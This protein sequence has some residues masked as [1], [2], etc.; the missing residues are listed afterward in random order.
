MKRSS[1]LLIKFAVFAGL[2]LVLWLASD[3]LIKHFANRQLADMNASIDY[4][5][6]RIS[7]FDLSLTVEELQLDYKNQIMLSV[8]QLSVDL[9]SHALTDKELHFDHL[10]IGSFYFDNPKFLELLEQR[11]NDQDSG[12]N[13]EQSSLPLLVIDDVSASGKL[14]FS[15]DKKPV[16]INDFGANDVSYGEQGYKAKLSAVLNYMQN[17]L[18]VAGALN[19]D[20]DQIKINLKKL[21]GQLNVAD[22]NEFSEINLPLIQGHIDF[23]ATA[24]VSYSQQ[25]LSI[26]SG[27]SDLRISDGLLKAATGADSSELEISFEQFQLDLSNSQFEMK[28]DALSATKIDIEQTDVVIKNGLVSG[29]LRSDNADSQIK[30]SKIQLTATESQVSLD[31]QNQPLQLDTTVNIDSERLDWHQLALNN[32]P[33]ALVLHLD[34]ATLLGID[35]SQTENSQSPT[36]AMDKMT[37]QTGIFSQVFAMPLIELNKDKTIEPLLEFNQLSLDKF[38]LA[39]DELVIGGIDIDAKH[40]I[41]YK[42]KDNA[43]ANFVD[44]F[45]SDEE[46]AAAGDV[47]DEDG[48]QANN[49]AKQK[50]TANAAQEHDVSIHVDRFNLTGEPVITLYDHSLSETFEQHVTIEQLSLS[51]V[52]RA[53]DESDSE[54][55][56]FSLKGRIGKRAR[57]DIDGALYPFADE[58]DLEAKG[59]LKAIDLKRYTPYVVDATGYAIK[60][61]LL[62]ADFQFAINNDVIKGDVDTRING[63]EISEL[64]NNKQ[65]GS[66]STMPI[67]V[68]ISQLSDEHGNVNVD[69]PLAGRIDD[70]NFGLSGFISLVTTKAIKEGAKTYLLQ[71]LVPY[72]SVVNVAMLASGSLFKVSVND[73][74]YETGQTEL[75][76]TQNEFIQ[77]LAELMQSKEEL[78]LTICPVVIGNS[79]DKAQARELRKVGQLRG[80]LFIDAMI[81]QYQIS[82]ERLI[83][84]RTKIVEKGVVGLTFKFN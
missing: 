76:P 36:V 69:V 29:V 7:P 26:A 43:I 31:Q 13:S 28:S 9:N 21:K 60:Q 12:D 66:V 34:A 83:P 11:T 35:I 44:L 72:A 51:N 14:L 64:Q 2:W 80:E 71:A 63:I 3:P 5:S 39:N 54:K 17:S 59:Q 32:E 78:H 33:K 6:A 16:T 50:P 84:C 56:K 79:E 4:K 48:Q 42:N 62:Y 55:A 10:H 47:P 74:P 8:E 82:D 27:Q 65:S 22:L 53:S 1:K 24:N 45:A 67:N 70:P 23:D 41:F 68:V 52:D 73:L 37:L 20:N 38:S 46:Q 19:S 58:R 25:G 49:A 77:P 75:R 30:F 57:I 18:S 81:E 40:V 61:G 15:D